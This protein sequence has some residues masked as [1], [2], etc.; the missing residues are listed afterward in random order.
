MKCHLP[1][2][3]PLNARAFQKRLRKLKQTMPSE[4]ELSA[5]TDKERAT[6]IKAVE[7]NNTVIDNSIKCVQPLADADL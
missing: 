2:D 4:A 7:T 5:L 1:Q 3:K 6:I